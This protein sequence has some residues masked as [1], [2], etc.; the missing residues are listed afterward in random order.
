MKVIY[1]GTPD[2][3]IS[4]LESIYQSSHEICLVVTQPD[5]PKGRGKKMVSPPIKTRA[6]ELGLKVQ[7]PNSLKDKEFVK[8]LE[9]LKADIIVVVAFSILPVK[10]IQTAKLG[11]INLH[12]SLL[13][14]Y[15]GAAPIQWALYY[16]EK[17]TGVSIFQLD[18]K[19][20][21]GELL[22]QSNVPITF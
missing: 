15:R 8:N 10:V 21:H 12:A 4:P 11:A 20:D 22:G 14:K 6:E 13:P 9:L 16:G 5:R 7:Q 2:I 17:M 1:M 3:A 18:A 19:M